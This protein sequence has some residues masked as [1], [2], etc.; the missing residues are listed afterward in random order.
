MKA[1]FIPL[2]LVALLAVPV[3]LSAQASFPR[4]TTVEP[5]VAKVGAV[6]SAV[7]EN[8]DKTNVAELLLTD[9]KSDVHVQITEQTTAS[10]KFKVPDSAKPGRFSLVIRTATTPP[11]EYVQPVKIT[12]E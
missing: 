9:G 3:F 7:G 12:V 4:M 2:M 11:K 8:L 5:A 10:L 1:S 6:V